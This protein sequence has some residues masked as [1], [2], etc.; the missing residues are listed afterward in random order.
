MAATYLGEFYASAGILAVAVG[1]FWL[2]SGLTWLDL[3]MGRLAGSDAVSLSFVLRMI[4]MA[5]MTAGIFDY[6]WVGS[7]TFFSRNIL[8]LV[9]FAGMAGAV[10]AARFLVGMH[11]ANH[12]GGWADAPAAGNSPERIGK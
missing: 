7:F 5:I 3:K 9:L 12:P 6:V 10:W 8:R 2:V 1:F 4:V 11:R